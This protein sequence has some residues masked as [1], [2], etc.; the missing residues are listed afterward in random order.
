M[1]CR[2]LKKCDAAR[3]DVI[4]KTGNTNVFSRQLDLCSLESIRE[5]AKK[6]VKYFEI[7]KSVLVLTFV[8]YINLDSWRKNS[9]WTF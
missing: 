8:N 4:A 7:F 5:F 2:D 1:A 6:L 9:D 3:D